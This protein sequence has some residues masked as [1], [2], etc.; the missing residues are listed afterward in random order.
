MKDFYKV[1]S[2]IAES[3]NPLADK[4]L[5]I[6]GVGK[7]KKTKKGNTLLECKVDEKKEA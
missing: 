5:G 4:K 6:A 2:S 7:K 1:E 3:Y